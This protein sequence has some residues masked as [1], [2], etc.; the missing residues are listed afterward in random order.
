MKSKHKVMR[1]AYRIAVRHHR[2]ATELRKKYGSMD[3]RTQM[4]WGNYR[5]FRDIF[6][7]AG[8]AKS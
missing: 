3:P 5:V 6:E 8:G 2:K 4:A 7:G 1:A